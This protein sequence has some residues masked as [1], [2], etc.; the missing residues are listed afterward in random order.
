MLIFHNLKVQLGLLRNF[1][2]M[3]SLLFLELI[4]YQTTHA[5]FEFQGEHL[6]HLV[7]LGGRPEVS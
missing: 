2:E 4:S 1:L 6:R 3:L 5:S 7:D